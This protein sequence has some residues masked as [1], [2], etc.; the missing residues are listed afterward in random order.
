[1][2]VWRPRKQKIPISSLVSSWILVLVNPGWK[3][4]INGGFTFVIAKYLLYLWRHVEMYVSPVEEFVVFVRSSVVFR[5]KIPGFYY[6]P[7]KII[8]QSTMRR[9]KRNLESKSESMVD[10]SRYKNL[11]THK[12]PISRGIHQKF[13]NHQDPQGLFRALF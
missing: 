4:L 5:R 3:Y 13:I 9:P 2:V 7:N 12:S 10:L 1:M 6:H 8:R 11:R